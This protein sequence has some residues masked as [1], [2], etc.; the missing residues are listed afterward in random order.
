VLAEN[1]FNDE[2]AEGN[3]YILVNYTITYTGD[4]PEGRT[5]ISVGLEYVTAG[6]NTIESYDS[7]VVAPDEIETWNTLY[8]GAST[9][10]NEAFEV[11]APA[12]GVLAVSPGMSAD[13]V[14][15]AIQ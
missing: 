9:T 15:V 1:Q 4:D 3:V 12:D 5:P 10:G 8:E 14:F 6:G 2:P 11:P 13:T 7:I